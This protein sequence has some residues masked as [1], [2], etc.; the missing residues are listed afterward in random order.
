MHNKNVGG[1]YVNIFEVAKEHISVRE[2]AEYYG[3]KINRNGMCSCLFHQERRPSMKLN[4]DYFYCFGCGVSGDVVKFTAKLFDLRN[5]EAAKKLISDFGL[6]ME[7]ARE[8]SVQKKLQY[9]KVKQLKQNEDYCQK[10]ITDYL[11]LLQK[12]KIDYAPIIS[13]EV[14]DERFLEACRMLEY[15]E[16]LADMLTFGEAKQR[17][18]LTE[19][20]F[21]DGTIT[22]IKK[23]LEQAKKKE[24]HRGQ[25]C[26]R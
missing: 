24:V 19:K 7:A 1:F 25:E 18:E 8:V 3:V 16:Y 2:A 11:H 20:L 10:V 21:K 14:W 15:V 13:E 17:A 9:Q 22:N 23:C 4:K 12:W 6:D 26:D 5:Y